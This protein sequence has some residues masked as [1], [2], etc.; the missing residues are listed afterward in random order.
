MVGI[1]E[2]FETIEDIMQTYD[3]HNKHALADIEEEI[4]SYVSLTFGKEASDND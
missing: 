1:I 4:K 2:L 3:I